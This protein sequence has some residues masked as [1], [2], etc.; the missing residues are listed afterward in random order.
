[1]FLG[2]DEI[3]LTVLILKLVCVGSSFEFQ[4]EPDRV[5]VMGLYGVYVA[6]FF[7]GRINWQKRREAEEEKF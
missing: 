5:G 6:L 3:S 7:H 1:M 2:I 4:I